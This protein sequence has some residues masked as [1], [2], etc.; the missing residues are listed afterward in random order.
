MLIA[1]RTSLLRQQTLRREMER[2]HREMGELQRGIGN[3][4]KRKR[5]R[6]GMVPEDEEPEHIE[7]VGAGRTP[8]ANELGNFQ[9]IFLEHTEEKRKKDDQN[10]PRPR[11]LSAAPRPKRHHPLLSVPGVALRFSGYKKSAS[12]STY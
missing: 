11:D 9:I 2:D 5:Q 6:A 7:E 4:R 3:S 10:A 8:L 1:V 12:A